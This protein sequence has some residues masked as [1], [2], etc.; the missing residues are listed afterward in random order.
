MKD[1]IYNYCKPGTVFFK[2]FPECEPGTNFQEIIRRAEQIAQDTFF[3]VV[4]VGTIKDVL[5][6]T[7][8]SKIFEYADMEVVYA[9]QPL[10]FSHS[11]HTNDTR[12]SLCSTNPELRKAAIAVFEK[13][14]R[15]AHD[16][17]ATAMRMTSGY[18]PDD[19]NDKEEAKKL[20]CDS[21]AQIMEKA[22]KYDIPLITMKIFDYDFDACQLIGKCEDALDIARQICPTYPKFG[23]LTDLS[24]FPLL[25]EDHRETLTA[26]K[27]YVKAFHLG[28][29]INTGDPLNPIYGDWQP[30]FGVP[31]GA[32]TNDD[33]VNYFRI[34]NDLELIGPD[35]RPVVTA[36]VRPLVDS[37]TPELI[38]ANTKRNVQRAWARA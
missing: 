7:R 27:D 17:H 19:P 31:N 24:H 38:L 32:H 14:M 15:E 30:R 35:K 29:T 22:E 16:L 10:F 34:L 6:R 23:L 12:Y 37:E 2:S 13:C 9:T 5:Y 8:V 4:E 28:N 33:I 1:S 18:M 26:L 36:E 20:L 11:G 3:E 21:I 25:R